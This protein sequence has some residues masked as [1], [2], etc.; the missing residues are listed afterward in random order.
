MD[1]T[2][3]SVGDTRNTTSICNQ[4][5]LFI[6][7]QFE[8]FGTQAEIGDEIAVY[9][10]SN[11]MRGRTMVVTHATSLQNKNPD[12]HFF[13]MGYLFSDHS[14]ENHDIPNSVPM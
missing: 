13:L 12:E 4:S 7:D 14:Y 11:I 6:G 1:P 5:V 8:I 10:K 2:K 9:D 3:E